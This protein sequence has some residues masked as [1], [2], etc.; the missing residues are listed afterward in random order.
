MNL[1]R[2][3]FSPKMLVPAVAV[4]ITG[5]LGFAL[6]TQ[7]PAR[8]ADCSD[9][10]VVHCGYT[11]PA[12]LANKVNADNNL[13]MLYNHP[14][15]PGYGIGMTNDWIKNAKHATA[16]KDGRV[17]LDDGTV[18]ATNAQS[19]G[20]QA[21]PGN[22]QTVNIG[23]T[24]YHF[25]LNSG[26]F[27]SNALSAFVLLSPDDHHM[28]FGALTAC[29]NP[30]W[31]NSPAYK[32]QM[33][34]Q[35][36]VNDTTYNYSTKVFSQ[37]ANLTKLVYDFGDGKTQVVTSNF[38]QKVPHT[39]MP[40]KYTAKVTAYFNAGGKEQSDTRAECSK[41]VDVPQPPP[42]PAKPVFACDNLT[43]TQINRTKY[44]F[45]AKGSSQNATFVSGSFTFDDNTSVASLKETAPGSQTVTTDHEFTEGDHTV[46][47]TLTYKE[48]TTPVTQ[49]CTAHI[50]VN[51]Q[52]CA[53]KPNAPE[54]QPPKQ[55]T[56]ADTPEA[57]NCKPKPQVLPSTGPV[58][59]VG[60]ALGLGSIAGAGVYY[61]SSR[62]NLIDLILKR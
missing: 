35:D 56:C 46:A 1:F 60:S 39:Y 47:A 37:G 62:R 55:Q 43:P 10:D 9:N 44:S 20:R 15:I 23:G 22:N 48:G 54:C 24:T 18:V 33:L 38:D 6:A 32:C 28:T 51:Q 21:I 42:P 31:G 5:L 13:R 14:F 45:T 53:E 61:R 36:K 19:L 30:V 52:T 40:G 34:N 29:G 49:K 58:E 27:A 3:I 7:T 17:V 12:D 4:T 26:N 50:T 2:Y 57:E 25:G 16:Y 59:I 11:T 41:P 8:A